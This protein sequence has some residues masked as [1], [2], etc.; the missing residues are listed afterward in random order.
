MVSLLDI[1]PAVAKLVTVN[2]SGTDVEVRGIS[3]AD[4]AYLVQHFPEVRDM[5]SGKDVEFTV[6][7]LLERAPAMVYDI[8]ACGT[9]MRGDSRAVGVASNLGID[10]Q[11]ALLEAILKETFKAGVGPFVERVTRLLRVGSDVGTKALAS[12]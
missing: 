9:G 7:S 2:V 12:K 5:F 3:L 4:I 10:D 11:L 1:A 6:D 8:I